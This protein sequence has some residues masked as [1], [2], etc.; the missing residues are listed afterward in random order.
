MKQTQK[1]QQERK[2]R[3]HRIED[4]V[5]N[6]KAAVEDGLLPGGG[7]LWPTRRPARSTSSTW[8][9]RRPRVRISCGSR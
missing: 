6:A 3:K 2:E 7:S 4:V 5:R 8:P 1:M 9:V